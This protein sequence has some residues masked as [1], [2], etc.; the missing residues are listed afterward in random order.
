MAAWIIGLALLN[1]AL[2]FAAAV[3]LGRRYRRRCAAAPHPETPEHA[4]DGAADLSLSTSDILAAIV[5]EADTRREGTPADRPP[6]SA[7]A[8]GA[9]LAPPR[10]GEPTAAESRCGAAVHGLREASR[11]YQGQLT[12]LDRRLRDPSTD[13]ASVVADCA[14]TLRKA[15]EEYLDHQRAAGEAFDTAY[16]ERPDLGN[17]RDQV[18]SALE[19]ETSQIRQAAKTLD[20]LDLEGGA[21]ESRQHVLAE[22]ARLL[23]ANDRLQEAL[24]AA[25]VETARSEN[26]LDAPWAGDQAD[27]PGVLTSRTGLER[28]LARLWQEHPR[29]A[30]PLA[31]A[32][33]D[34][35]QFGRINEHFGRELGDRIL[36]AV[37]TLVSAEGPEQAISARF[38]GQRF[39]LAF[40]DG[41]LGRA[42]NAVERI[43]QILEKAHFRRNEFDLQ[44]T[45]SCGIAGASPD[46]TSKTVC[47]RAEAAMLEAKRYG[48]NRTFIHEGRYPTPVAPPNLVVPEKVVDL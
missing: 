32:A 6:A 34:L 13:D 28:Q 41:D 18:R 4:S 1:G 39:V 38:S 19:S 35:D 27:E 14:A 2:G 9:S 16:G 25:L 17:V 15:S 46:D 29:H 12:E 44:V 43:R 23:G 10:S 5:P 7:E 48:R 22:T 24:D 45:V 20:S 37:A 11:Q 40:P 33:I 42:V 21:S 26:L 30:P 8:G 36:R 47:E 31:V 3:E